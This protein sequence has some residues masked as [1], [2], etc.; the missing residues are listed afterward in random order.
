MDEHLSAPHSHLGVLL[1]DQ[2]AARLMAIVVANLA[3]FFS[4]LKADV[5]LA[6]DY[7]S[8]AN[9]LDDLLPAALAVALITI[10]NGLIT[11]DT[12]A[13]LVYWRWANPLP[14]CRAFS[15]HIHSDPRIDVGSLEQKIG[16]L[17]ED[18]REQNATWYRLYRTV[19]SDAAVA[20][21][22]R[23]FLFARDYTGLAVMLLI[24]LGGLSVYQIDDWSRTLPYITLLAAQ[25]LI[26]RHVARN[27]GHRFVTTVLAV[28]AA[29][30]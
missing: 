26:V 6:A 18:E 14:G 30:E 8:L 7:Q 28:K 4:I 16:K 11:P 27:Y 22:H 21:L 12:K 24:V 25:Y 10:V 9:N 15:E 23:D 5:L 3:M 1:K 20:H 29:E 17:P 2:N 19:R 13:R